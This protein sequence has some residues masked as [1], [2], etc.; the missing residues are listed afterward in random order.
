M[1][2][3]CDV[4]VKRNEFWMNELVLDLRKGQV[5]HTRVRLPINSLSKYSSVIS[6]LRGWGGRFD[7]LLAD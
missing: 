6:I 7:P 1:L 2:P 3:F 5:W 4:S